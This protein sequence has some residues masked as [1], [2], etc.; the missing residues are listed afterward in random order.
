[1]E[2]PIKSGDARKGEAEKFNHHRLLA[3]PDVTGLGGVGGMV[4]S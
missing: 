1:M 4:E 3:G 2:A